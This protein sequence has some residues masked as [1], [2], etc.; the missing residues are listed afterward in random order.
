MHAFY[1]ILGLFIFHVYIIFIVL[2]LLVS[3]L[4]R[5]LF[6]IMMMMPMNVLWLSLKMY[7]RAFQSES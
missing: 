2:V 3:L 6:L 1:I 7:V 4:S 5:L